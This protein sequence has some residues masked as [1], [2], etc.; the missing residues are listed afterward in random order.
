MKD[1]VMELILRD[2]G[3]TPPSALTEK[4][5]EQIAR[6][7]RDEV[8][9]QVRDFKSKEKR[10]EVDYPDFKFESG[11]EDTI[12]RALKKADAFGDDLGKLRLSAQLIKDMLVDYK[13][14]A[15]NARLIVRVREAV[16]VSALTQ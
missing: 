13:W 14:S 10:R 6:I 4:D 2:V 16:G 11:T 7:T 5:V 1:E 12:L 3:P 9:I 15:Q 8:A